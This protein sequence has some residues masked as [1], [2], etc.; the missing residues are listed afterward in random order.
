MTFKD[1]I[2]F[3]NDNP[4]SFMA[5]IDNDQPRVRTMLLWYADESGF[6]YQTSDSKQI[7]PQL[8]ANPKLEICFYK[9]KDMVDTML[10]V[11]GEVEFMDDKE[12]REKVFKAR[13]FLRNLG[14]T[15]ESSGLYIMRIAHGEAYIFNS[16]KVFAPKEF[17]T[18]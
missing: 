16:L 13:P 18:F 17:I 4:V 11:T 2:K 6:Y 3:A 9:Q 8:K 1:C 15:P 7:Y 14:Y 10:R 12:L 5:T